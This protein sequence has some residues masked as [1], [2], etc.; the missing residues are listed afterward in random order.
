MDHAEILSQLET[1]HPDAFGW[2]VSCA[3]GNWH[4]GQDVL[5]AAYAK[6]LRGTVR[7]DGRSS[8]KTWWFGVIR[9]TAL[10]EARRSR[11]WLAFLDRWRAQP[12]AQETVAEPAADDFELQALAAALR[13]LSERQREVLHL[14]FYQRLSLSEAAEVMQVSIGSARQHYD[15]GKKR[16]RE[17]LQARRAIH[18]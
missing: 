9:F 1:L 6:A 13:E 14:T 7:F 12:D 11:R 3:V 18:E 17:F 15:R 2:A 4:R 10:E 5:Q 8:F 16:L